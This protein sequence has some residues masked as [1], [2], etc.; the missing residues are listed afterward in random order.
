MPL[1][2]S[3]KRPEPVAAPGRRVSSAGPGGH[4]SRAFSRPRSTRIACIAGVGLDVPA[5]LLAD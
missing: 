4:Q 1:T 3:C 2:I 5:F